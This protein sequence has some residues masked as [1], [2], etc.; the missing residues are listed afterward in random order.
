M[1][2]KQYQS[3]NHEDRIY[4]LWLNHDCFNP[5]SEIN[6]NLKTKSKKSEEN[7]S[8]IMPPP[9]ANDLSM[10]DMRCLLLLRIY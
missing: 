8:L 7:F 1:L 10:L 5:D 3:Q 9:N 4:Q 6:Q 2:D